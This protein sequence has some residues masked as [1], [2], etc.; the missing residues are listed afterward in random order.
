MT[1]SYSELEDLNLEAKEKALKRVDEGVLEEYYLKY[2]SDN[3]DIKAVTV[4]FTDLEGRFHM[5]DYDK[6]F[7]LRS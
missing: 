2:L 6:K 1:Y 7:L 3:K 4:A 5:L